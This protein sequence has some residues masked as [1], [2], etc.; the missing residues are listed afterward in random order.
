[1]C[2]VG[3]SALIDYKSEQ[4]KLDDEVDKSKFVKD[5]LAFANTYRPN[6]ESGYILIGIRE[7][8]RHRGE[9]DGIAN[10]LDGNIYQQLIAEGPVPTSFKEGLI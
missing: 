5:I 7:T 9:V 2:L 1:M 3:E 4:Y 6:G 10:I 8:E